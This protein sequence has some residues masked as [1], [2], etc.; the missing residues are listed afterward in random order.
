MLKDILRGT[1]T[2]SEL[3]MVPSSFEVIGS[4]DRSVAIIEVP[5]GLKDSENDLAEA[6]MHIQKSVRSVLSKESDREGELRL[7]GYRLI[8]GEPDTEVIHRE[9]GYLLKVDPQKTYFSPREMTE[10]RRVASQ[11]K[12][13]EVVMVMFS[14]IA[15]FNIAIAKLQ[16]D[17][18]KVY[19]VEL[20][21]DAHAMGIESVRINRL[22]HKITLING[23]VNEVCPKYFGKCD[24]VL[25][26]LPMGSESFLET[27]IKC[28]RDS[29]GVLHFY[30]WGKE[31]DLYTNAT[32]MISEDCRKLGKKLEVIGERK[33]LP[34]SPRKWKICI[35]VRII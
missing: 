16:P 20:N 22:S 3:E 2:E 35:D 7:R 15:P 19:G 33:V 4:K 12:P 29:G 13:G 30:N 5:E 28:L 8:A 34:Y 17:V 24:R 6:I 21:K 11:V 14:G 23:D 18:E 26:P 31:E 25:M 9:N 32:N 10:R 1:L 27:A